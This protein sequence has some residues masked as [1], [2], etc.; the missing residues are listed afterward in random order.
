MNILGKG[1]KKNGIAVLICAVVLATLLGTL[2]GC[3]QKTPSDDGTDREN[4][5][6]ALNAA[7]ESEPAVAEDENDEPADDT[8]TLANDI[9]TNLEQNYKTT[10]DILTMH[11]TESINLVEGVDQIGNLREIDGVTYVPMLEDYD[12]INEIME[13]FRRVYTEDKC[14]T[15]YSQYL[16]S[17]STGFMKEVD[18][19]LYAMA[20]GEQGHNFFKLPITG[21]EKISDTEILAKTSTA[22]DFG[23]VPYE[24]T[25][26]YEDGEWKI[27]RLIEYMSEEG[28]EM[29]Y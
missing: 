25:L 1:T 12:T 13:V 10:V 3:T 11:M 29:S 2:V 24:I 19:K 14:D 17:D 23:D 7:D 26:K 16:D 6:D 8:A 5:T 18:G 22:Y 4:L 20:I 21:A 9:L 27:D 28:R 15:L